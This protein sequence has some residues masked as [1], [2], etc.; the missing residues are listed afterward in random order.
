MEKTY[1]NTP[2]EPGHDGWFKW[3]TIDVSVS[4]KLSLKNN[5]WWVN[6]DA[7][8]VGLGI[9]RG[10]LTECSNN[11]MVWTGPGAYPAPKEGSDPLPATFNGQ[12]CFTI[13]TD[14]SVW[15]K[16]KAAW[17]NRHPNNQ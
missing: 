14:K 11:I 8:Y 16:A 15:D 17:L 13:T 5:V 3:D 6:Q 2:P 1:K 12:P 9:P 4:P 10:R 7:T